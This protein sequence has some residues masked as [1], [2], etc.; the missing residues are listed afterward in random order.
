VGTTAGLTQLGSS[1]IAP[2]LVDWFDNPEANSWLTLDNRL[3]CAIAASPAWA[4]G[5]P[6]LAVGMTLPALRRT[7]VPI[8]PGKGVQLSVL[9]TAQR[10]AP[11][12]Y[13]EVTGYDLFGPPINPPPGGPTVK[14][15]KRTC[16]YLLHDAG[17][18]PSDLLY[19]PE[20]WMPAA[21][22]LQLGPGGGGGR[23]VYWVGNQPD[24]ANGLALSQQLAYVPADT[25]NMALTFTLLQTSSVS[26]GGGASGNGFCVCLLGDLY[27]QPA[28]T[29]LNSAIGDQLI[30]GPSDFVGSTVTIPGL[31]MQG[32][33]AGLGSLT[34]STDTYNVEA[35]AWLGV[36]PQ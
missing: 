30:F 24:T 23:G 20:S 26:G 29:N 14:I 25:A 19:P 6:D 31:G 5:S 7:T 34:P 12:N 4:L 9:D 15:H 36:P 22:T 35:V 16:P 10:T 1:A 18:A 28:G 3:P 11:A 13:L 33:G 32:F 8:D 27:S 21:F 2:A 17:A